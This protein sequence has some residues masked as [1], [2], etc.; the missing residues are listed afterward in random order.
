[1]T[2]KTITVCGKEV[3]FKASAALPRLY[4]TMFGRDAFKDMEVVE[5][6]ILGQDPASSPGV[7]A[8]NN[9]TLENIAYIMAKHADPDIPDTVEE[10]LEQFEVF[11]IYE[12]IP[13]IP[14]LWYA[15]MKTNIKAKKKPDQQNGK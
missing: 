6:A 13:V 5:R 10:W 11:S 4:R 14:D 1:M 2:E 7:P 9:E 12:I 15:N 8:D 3:K